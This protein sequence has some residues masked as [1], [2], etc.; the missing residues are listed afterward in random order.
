MATSAQ[1]RS[2]R[3]LGTTVRLVAVGD[4]TT[5]DRALARGL[6][7]LDEL[8]RR[9]SRFRPASELSVLNAAGGQPV[10]TS[11]D[12][13]RLLHAAIDA[14]RLT[15]GRF[16]PTV[17]PALE[18]AG[19]DRS[20]ELLEAPHRSAGHDAGVTPGR[21]PLPSPGPGGMVIDDDAGTVRLSAGVTLDLGG[22]G[23][24]AIA[25]AV[26]AAM[27][28]SGASGACVDLGGDV[29]VA[30]TPPDGEPA[31][32]VAVADPT[33]PEDGDAP[34][35]V[36]LTLIEGAV[37]TSATTQRRWHGPLGDAHH[38]I[39]P[40]TGRP[41]STDV[42]SATVLAASARDAEV[43]AKAAVLAGMDAGVALLSD[44]GATGLLVGEDGWV[45][46]VHGL[47]AFTAT[48]LASRTTRPARTKEP[49]A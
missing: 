42:V 21:N 39:D 11:G 15:D 12:T 34:P 8:D 16:D 33:A 38:L 48:D 46:P 9:W 40:R 23:K 19:Y 7:R 1:A 27:L 24:G 29:A 41:A 45:I 17:L 20:F 32:G 44:N 37:A 49:T 30:G 22:I 35:L 47:D 5:I 14:W 10:P 43:L 2:C 3:R 36:Q 18:A 25:D 28:A 13:R 6:A 31:W 4:L 26:V